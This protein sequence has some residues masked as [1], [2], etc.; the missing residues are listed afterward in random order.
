MLH[1]RSNWYQHQ[2]RRKRRWIRT[3]Y[4]QNVGMI[5]DQL[6]PIATASYKC[7]S[8]QSR[9]AIYIDIMHWHKYQ[10]ICHSAK[11]N[12][13][14]ALLYENR[15][16]RLP[17]QISGMSSVGCF[18]CVESQLEG[19]YYVKSTLALLMLMPHLHEIRMGF[20]PD[21]EIAGCAFAGNA[22]NVFPATEG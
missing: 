11:D 20:L 10:D 12:S 5:R 18:F 9:Q 13:K 21:T 6:L 14:I 16:I 8:T 2:T 3:P 1:K 17:Y 7:L 22:G 15:C 4:A 19:E